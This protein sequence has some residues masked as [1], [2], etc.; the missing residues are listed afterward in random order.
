MDADTVHIYRRRLPHWRL[1]GATYFVTW[2]L[3][4]GQRPLMPEERTVVADAFHFFD[5]QRYELSAYVVMDDHV[6]VIVTP[7]AHARL[8][9]IY[10]SW[11]SYTA[12]HFQRGS[13]RR[14]RV[15]QQEPF[16]RIVRDEAEL[17]EKIQYILNNPLKR[18]PDITDYPWVWAKG[19][20]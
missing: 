8:Q 4:E 3:A 14:G 11:K 17:S 1:P 19:V 15:W 18:W 16:D 20:E 10:H 7:L 12:R 5:Q 2:R 13:G 6:H 9:D